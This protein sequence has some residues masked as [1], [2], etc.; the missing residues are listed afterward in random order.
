MERHLELVLD[1]G[2]R[3][4]GLVRQILAFSRQGETKPLKMEP[5][6]IIKEAVKLLRSTIP[7]TIEIDVRLNTTPLF[8]IADPVQLQQVVMNHHLGIAGLR[9]HR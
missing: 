5:A 9:S 4:A 8:I 3:A 1:A 2:H 6:L 7:S